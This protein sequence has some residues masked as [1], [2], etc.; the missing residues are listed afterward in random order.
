MDFLAVNRQDLN[1][2]GHKGARSQDWITSSSW[3]FVSFLVRVFVFFFVLAMKLCSL[4]KSNTRRSREV[5][6]DAANEAIN[7]FEDWFF[8]LNLAAG[9]VIYSLFFFAAL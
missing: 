1:H 6:F 9:F 5:P 7:F 4:E 8:G 2:K 3:F